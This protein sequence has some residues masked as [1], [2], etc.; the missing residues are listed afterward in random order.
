MAHQSGQHVVTVLPDGFAHHQR[1]V[2][3]DIAKHFDAIFLAVDEAVLF[4]A[5]ERMAPLDLAA[6]AADGLHERVFGVLLRGPTHTVGGKAQI[7]TGNQINEGGHIEH[8][9]RPSLSTTRAKR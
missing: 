6:F 3:R 5:I 8:S 4:F 2:L 9:N 1:R 7:A